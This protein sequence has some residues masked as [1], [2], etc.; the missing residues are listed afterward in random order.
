MPAF[1][2]SECGGRGERTIVPTF[3][4]D[5]GSALGEVRF[6]SFIPGYMS[7]REDG[8][9]AGLARL[10]EYQSTPEFRQ[11]MNDGRLEHARAD[12]W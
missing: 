11:K 7:A 5:C 6:N 1:A 2:C 8:N 4:P 10:K 12:D 9:S 3:C